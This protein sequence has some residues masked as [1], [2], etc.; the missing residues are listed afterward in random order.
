[1]EAFFSPRGVAIAGASK[2]LMKLGNVPIDNLLRFGYEGRIVPL[3][4]D[5]GEIMGLPAYSSIEEAG[6][7]VDLAV[8][9]IP[10]ENVL[11]FLRSCARAEVRNIIVT[12]AGFADADE[13]GENLQRELA[14]AARDLSVRVMG[15]NSIGTINTEN[16][17]VT[18]IVTLE[19]MPRGPVSVV[20]Q[21]GLFAAGFVRWVAAGQYCGAATVSCLGN[22]ADIDEVDVLEHLAGEEATGVI[23]V[24]TEGTRDGKRFLD[25]LT[26]VT[27]S[28][29]VV[30]FKPGSSETGRVAARSHTGSLGVSHEMFAAAVSQGGGIPAR[31]FEEMLDFAKALALSPAPAGN[32]LGVV[33]VTGAG[34]SITA[35]ACEERG[36]SL[37]PL[38]PASLRAAAEGLPPW[39][40]FANPADIWAPIMFE[41]NAGAYYKLLKAMASQDDIDML[42]AIFTITPQFEFDAAAVIGRLREE[43]EGKPFLACVLWGGAAE[44]ARWFGSF[45]DAGVPA[46]DS[47]ERAVASAGALYLSASRRP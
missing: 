12:A 2:T 7:G 35:D 44:S 15:P 26:R 38:K 17:F 27:R 10:R 29:P 47:I 41:G 1:M 33:S 9:V 18:S 30:V 39:V 23:A 5:A 37:P 11:D 20:A 45:R 25:C 34:C 42:L 14:A 16:G 3:N 4:P 21:S 6:G 46:Y 13:A 22:K 8:A 40:S 19:P 32:R 36:L 24:H 31:S 28:K 43:F